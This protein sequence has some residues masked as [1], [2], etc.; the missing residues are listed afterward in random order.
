MDCCWDLEVK[1]SLKN[2]EDI[3]LLLSD[4]DSPLMIDIR[5]V[6]STFKKKFEQMVSVEDL[7]F[8]IEETAGEYAESLCESEEYKEFCAELLE[9]KDFSEISTFR[10]ETEEEIVEVYP[11]VTYCGTLNY[12]FDTGKGSK[13]IKEISEDE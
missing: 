8:F 2:G 10:I 3:V 9:I 13:K 7:K 4:A 1:V 5:N 12:N 6:K 11:E